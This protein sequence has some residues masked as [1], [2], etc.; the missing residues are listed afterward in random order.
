MKANLRLL[1]TFAD[2]ADPPVVGA[3]LSA[4]F[5]TTSALDGIAYSK[6]NSSVLYCPNAKQGDDEFSFDQLFWDMGHEN[7]KKFFVMLGTMKG[8]DL[9]STREVIRSRRQLDQS[10]KD[11]EQEM[12][13]CLTNIENIE[14]FQRK[15][16]TCDHKMEAT[17]NF[18]VEQTVMRHRKL[19]CP[20]GFFAYNCDACKD[21]CER[22]ITGNSSLHKKKRRCEKK[23]C[24]CPPSDHYLEEREWCKIPEKVSKTLQDM[25]AQYELNYDGK[26]TAEKILNAC[27]EDLQVARAKVLSLL[28]QVAKNVDLL[29]STALRSNVLSPSDYLS[30][31]RSRVLEEQAPGYLTR[32]ETLD[33]LQRMLAGGSSQ[34]IR[35]TVTRPNQELTRQSPNTDRESYSAVTSKYGQTSNKGQT[36]QPPSVFSDGRESKPGIFQRTADFFGLGK[37]AESDNRLTQQKEKNKTWK[38]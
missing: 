10:L 22:F 2:N 4:N 3:C 18:T 27:S 11:I 6:F 14:I 7:F 5:P 13:V 29:E 12:E 34:P 17:K 36:T 32:L 1:V 15:M 31:M 8:R 9:T 38:V 25:K 28:E 35:S 23:A 21:T 37:T 33:D 30:L 24:K 26:M 20:N 16:K 19:R